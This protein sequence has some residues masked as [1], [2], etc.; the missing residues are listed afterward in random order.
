MCMRVT[1]QHMC[2]ANKCINSTSKYGQ[3]NFD[4]MLI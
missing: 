1:Y 4:H 2:M 3:H